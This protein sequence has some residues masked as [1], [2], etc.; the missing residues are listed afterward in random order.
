MGVF[1]NEEKVQILKDV[2]GF[3]T[4]NDNELEV[5][6]Y[7]KALFQ[8]HGIEARIDMVEG[9][10]ANLIAEIGE[11]SPVLGISGH[12]DVVAEGNHSEWT[13]DPFTLTEADGYL[14]GRGAGDM[15]SGLVALAIAMIEIHESGVL[16]RGRIKFMATTGEEMEQLGSKQLYEN[17]EMDDVDALVIAEPSEKMLVYAHK[18]SMD[19]RITSKGRAAHSSM[20]VIGQNAIKPLMQ[21]VQHIDDEFEKI[22]KALNCERLNFET[23]LD[24]IK[25]ML[26]ENMDMDDVSR[27]L[28]GL[29]ITNTIFNGGTQVNSVPGQATAEF[30]VRTVPEYDN[31]QVK[32]LFNHYLELMNQQGANLEQDVYLDL[33]PVIT[34][35][36]NALVRLGVETAKQHFEH[37]IIV[38]PTVGVTDASNL[39]RGKDEHFSFMMFGPGER[40]HQVD[41]RVKKASYLNFI[42]YYI[43]LFT[44]YLSK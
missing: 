18:G 44:T 30:N 9:Q 40:A 8:K 29:V 3:K 20:P 41:E 19:F 39:L 34:T 12:M 6:H 21:F 13:Y 7:F 35:G 33:D 32:A 16:K 28:Y 27:V 14:Y 4:V 43:A 2:V 1:T 31:E 23:F 17:G 10:R 5:C 42:D 25:P 37:D 26:S 15:K 24:Y 22:S 38:S 36:D 11:G